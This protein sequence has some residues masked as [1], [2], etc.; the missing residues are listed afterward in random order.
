MRVETQHSGI[1]PRRSGS[2][3][4]STT[5]GR[6]TSGNG[7]LSSGALPNTSSGPQAAHHTR[8]HVTPRSLCRTNDQGIDDPFT[9]STD[10]DVPMYEGEKANKTKEWLAPH[11]P[12]SQ[13]K[14]WLSTGSTAASS[15]PTH[16]AAGGHIS[17][18]AFF[19]HD[20]GLAQSSAP[21]PRFVDGTVHPL[22]EEAARAG[23]ILPP[24]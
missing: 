1:G 15:S 13:V 9:Q 11:D 16:I 4:P 23:E 10:N 2:A 17:P 5:L 22:S 3:T 19:A 21:S 24:H 7:T 12:V 14:E 8:P 6:T 20:P 18:M